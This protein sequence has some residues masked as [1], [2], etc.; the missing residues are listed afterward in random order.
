MEIKRLIYSNWI[1]FSIS[2]LLTLIAIWILVRY[3]RTQHPLTNDFYFSV[4]DVDGVVSSIHNSGI[5]PSETLPGSIIT[6]QILKTEYNN[7]ISKQI[8]TPEII[9]LGMNHKD[10]KW[11]L[12]PVSIEDLG[13]YYIVRVH[14]PKENPLYG[15]ST[16]E[17][18]SELIEDTEEI[19]ECKV[20]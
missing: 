2:I 13:L 15:S 10:L 3:I 6:L 17:P 11:S 7:G 16:P 18:S 12:T 4:T 14:S 1:W 5:K 20:E 9:K 8:N 19:S